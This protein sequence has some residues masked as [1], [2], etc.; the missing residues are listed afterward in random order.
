MNRSGIILLTILTFAAVYAIYPQSSINEVDPSDLLNKVLEHNSLIVE[1]ERITA[2]L[3]KNY[4]PQIEGQ[5]T[6]SGRPAYMLRLKP[7]VK[8]RPWK[9]LWVD[10]KTY[11]IL[12]IRD[13]TAQN[14]IK[15]SIIVRADL[16]STPTRTNQSSIPAE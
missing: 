8:H 9:Q 16:Q 2:L 5:D 15:R 12:A 4:T 10:E 14:R 1:R 11:A 13:W 7:D 3:K 6:I